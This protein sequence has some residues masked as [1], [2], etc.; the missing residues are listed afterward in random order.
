MAGAIAFVSCWLCLATFSNK[1]RVIPAMFLGLTIAS[2]GVAL[3]QK[4]MHSAS[5]REQM[6]NTGAQ[7][8][9]G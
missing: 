7:G 3:Y 8:M 9:R 4:E 5:H 2:F 6:V 1:D